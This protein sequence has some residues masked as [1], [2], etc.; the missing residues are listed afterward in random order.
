MTWLQASAVGH[1]MR[2]S[3]VWTYAIVNL[4]HI[5]GVASFFGAIL[6]LD[7]SLVGLRRHIP[8]VALVDATAPVAACGFALA[9]TTGIG[10]FATKATE[11]YDNPFLYIKFAAIGAGLVNVLVLQRSTAWQHRDSLP[12]SDAH[13]R[14]LAWMAGTSLACWLTAISAGRLIGYW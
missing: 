14:R 12:L 9:V 13:R 10:L 6:I 4:L 2:E 7:L 8:V 11:Y 5:L 1:F 3:G